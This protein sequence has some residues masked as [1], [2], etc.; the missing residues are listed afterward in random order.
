MVVAGSGGEGSG[1]LVFNEHGALLSKVHS[2]VEMN[3][4]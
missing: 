2:A 3:G 1:E 4:R